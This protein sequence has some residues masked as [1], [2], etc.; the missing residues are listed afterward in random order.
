[1][2]EWAAKRFW[3][4]ASCVAEGGGYAIHLDGRPVRTPAKAQLI[5]PTLALAQAVAAEWDAQSEKIDPLTMPNTRSAN[6][7]LDKVAPQRGA[8]EAMIADYA[9]TDL[10]CYRATG[11]E[12][13]IARQTE[14]WDP[15]LD[16]ART[17]LGADLRIT[18]G[19]MPIAQAPSALGILTG[20][21][22][23]MSDFTLV[24]F[25]D[26]VSLSGSFV[27]A[28]AV[29]K[30][31]LT[32]DQAWALSRLDEEWQAQLWGHDEDAT[33]KAAL[34]KADFVH[35]HRFVSLANR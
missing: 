29:I 18:S 13:L 19:V 20:Q 35:A 32:P 30:G 16:W 1:M 14:Q 24:G 10:L 22:A 12:T 15:I 33:A 7:A 4:S 34:K 2:A 3:K 6:A 21:M 27:L 5:L 31:R 9:G 26:L 25:H 23:D 11:P 28:L 17:D 8:V